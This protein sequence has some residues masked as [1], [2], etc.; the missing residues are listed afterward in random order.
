M[1]IFLQELQVHEGN[2]SFLT[3]EYK[4]ILADENKLKEE[5]KKQPAHLERL[6]GI[7]IHNIKIGTF[8]PRMRMYSQMNTAALIPRKVCIFLAKFEVQEIIAI[9]AY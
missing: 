2:V 3:D 5:F 7:F 6:Y 8:I 4:L 1:N 9:C